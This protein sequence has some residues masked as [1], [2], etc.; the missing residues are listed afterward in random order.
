MKQTITKTECSL[1][2]LSS[3]SIRLLSHILITR[4]YTITK[5]L[6][7]EPEDYQD[8]KS[9]PHVQVALK[10]RNMGK[11][12]RQG[13]YILP[14]FTSRPPLSA[15]SLSLSLSLCILNYFDLSYTYLT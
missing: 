7:K 5:G 4:I 1:S 6:T 8:A 15:L 13:D 14:M 2:P 11:R 10:M 3:L 12:V 9:Q